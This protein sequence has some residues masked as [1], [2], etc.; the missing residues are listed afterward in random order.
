MGGCHDG[1]P[2]LFFSIRFLTWPFI[3]RENQE[4]LLLRFSTSNDTMQVEATF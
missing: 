3:T 1:F 2:Y 4:K